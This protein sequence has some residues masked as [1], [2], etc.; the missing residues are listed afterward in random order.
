MIKFLS[1]SHKGQPGYTVA[2]ACLRLPG[3][4]LQLDPQ[5]ALNSQVRKTQQ[6]PPISGSP[7]GPVPFDMF[8]LERRMDDSAGE[9]QTRNTRHTPLWRNR[10]G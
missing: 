1:G 8:P 7:L 9:S 6:N 4:F 2:T 10:N 3:R 5:E